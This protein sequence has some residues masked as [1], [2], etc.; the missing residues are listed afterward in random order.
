MPAGTLGAAGCSRITAT[1]IAT[2]DDDANAQEAHLADTL[3]PKNGGVTLDVHTHRYWSLYA[4]PDATF[5][6]TS[7]RYC[8][9][10]T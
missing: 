4:K 5:R 9:V 8:H 7:V 3:L 2:I 6:I 10:K 1:E